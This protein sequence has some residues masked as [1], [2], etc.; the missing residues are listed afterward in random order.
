M[1]QTLGIIL[2]VIILLLP[3]PVLAEGEGEPPP[4]APSLVI[5]TG[6]LYPGMAK[7]Y[8]SGY[9]PTVSG[10]RAVFVLPLLGD[11]QGNI[12][13]VTPNISTDG[14]FVYGNYQ[15]E[16]RRSYAAAQD[17]SLHDIFLIQLDIALSASRYNGIY[18]VDF[19]VD[20]KNTNGEAMQQTFT[21]RVTI[22]DGKKKPVEGGGGSGQPTVKKPVL[23]ISSHSVRP[24]VVDGGESFTVSLTIENVGDLDAKNIRVSLAPQDEQITFNGEMNA[25]FT[26]LLKKN[27]T[28]EMSFSMRALAVASAGEHLLAA[29]VT[30]ED[31]YGT[32]YTEEGTFSIGVAQPVSV[33]FDRIKLPE[34][35]E[36]GTSLEQP[37]SV[38]NTGFATVYNVKCSFRVDGILA[39]T[40]YLG[41]IEPQQSAEKTLSLFATVLSGSNPYGP[42]SGEMFIS[43]TDAAGQE[44]Q[45]M[46]GVSTT[47]LEPDLVTDAELEKQKQEQ[48]EQQTLSQWWMSLL[49]GIAVIAIL[50]SVIITTKF[51]RMM[52]MK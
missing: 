39:A 25:I 7:T 18:P 27:E 34:T 14:P 28:E 41:M 26:Q 35:I 51:S 4:A 48:K 16:L 5:D 1:K 19:V 45:D 23:L 15:F 10:G 2:A 38:F 43:Y 20:Y 9:V 21:L 11:T 22:T 40:A 50:V 32:A 3:L 31:R 47:I 49:I 30:Y 46:V 17:Q 44:Y 33:D 13:R 36:S 24:S 6:T 42:T 12:I 37:I 29:T 8:Q 52:K